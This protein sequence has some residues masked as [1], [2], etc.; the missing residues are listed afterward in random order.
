MAVQQQ[1]SFWARWLTTSRGGPCVAVQRNTDRAEVQAGRGFFRCTFVSLLPI[2]REWPM[3][4]LL[5]LLLE[6]ADRKAVTASYGGPDSLRRL[7]LLH[8]VPC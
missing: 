4:L 6:Y 2:T 3:L 5:L 7:A 1:P 8:H